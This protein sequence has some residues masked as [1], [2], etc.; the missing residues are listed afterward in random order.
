MIKKLRYLKYYAKVLLINWTANKDSYAQHGEDKLVEQLLPNGVNSFID[1]GANDGVLFSNTYKFAKNGAMGLCLEPS[2][3]A[4]KKLRL[5]HLIHPRIKCVQ[6]AVSN[7]IG[8]IFL[9]EDGYEQTLSKVCTEPVPG[10]FK[11][12]TVTFDH[13]LKKYPNFINIDLLSIDV[14]G[15]EKNV[16]DG[17]TN[18]KFNA[19]LIIIESDKS[20]QL[21]ILKGNYI[22]YL[23][24][25]VNL[26][27]VNKLFK[28]K[29]NF[30]LPCGY[31]FIKEV[32]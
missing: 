25:G 31:K 21:E 7:E 18:D 1:I 2:P 23:T 22:P 29:D 32:K 20:G 9:K 4:Y 6:C 17:L 5:N 11:I 15:H 30:K 24:N 3:N 28:L 19:K 26:V 27:Y 8:Q 10:S 16:L 13:I 12:S 14:E